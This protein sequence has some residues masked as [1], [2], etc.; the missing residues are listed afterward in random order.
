MSFHEKKRARRRRRTLT[1][2]ARRRAIHLRAIHSG[3]VE[4]VDCVCELADFYFAKR[5]SHACDCRKRR[6]GRPRVDCGMCHSG[7]RDRIYEWRQ[8][9]RKLREAVV[10]GRDP[11]EV[12]DPNRSWPSTKR[13]PRVFAIEKRDL[14]KQGEPRTGWYTLIRRYRTS[15]DRDNALR[16]L[17][18][19]AK[20][21]YSWGSTP[22]LPVAC[23]LRA[24]FRAAETE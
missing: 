4:N 18:L 10:S 13:A 8:E 15:A 11:E 20:T 9:T 21:G 2:A 1:V 6:K 23:W 19:Q 3:K 5:T 16:S 7:M 17:R 12:V 14:N 24:E 22:G